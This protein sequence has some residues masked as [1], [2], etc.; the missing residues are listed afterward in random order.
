MW[1]R[2]VYQDRHGRWF[3][4]TPDPESELIHDAIAET[5]R[6]LFDSAFDN[7]PEATQLLEDIEGLDGNA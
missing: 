3:Q 5:D 1:D 7:D 2:P 6:E 4:D